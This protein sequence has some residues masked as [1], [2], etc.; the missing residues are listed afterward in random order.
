MSQAGILSDS[1]SPAADV[2][3]LQGNSGGKV[4]PDA[5]FN[6][7]TVGTGSITID[8]NPGTNTLT[9]QLTGLTNHNVLVGAG[10]AT[11]TK[12]A[13]SAGTGIALVSNGAAADPSFTTVSVAGGGLG[14]TTVPSNGQIPIGN[15]TNYTVANL[16]AGTGI[17]IAN[18]AGSITISVSGTGL[19][20]T[21]V[22]GT[23]QT[24]A[25]SNGY[26]SDNAGTVTFTLP[27]TASLGDT[28]Q[29]VGKLGAWTIAQNANQ[30]IRVS[31]T[32]STVG[33]GGSVSS[34]NVGDCI[35]CTCITSGASTVWRAT[36]VVGN[37]TVV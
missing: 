23:T 35:E 24:I 34:T 7:F 11:I 13:P 31:G 14:V 3:T 32:N 33:V 22:T 26:V 28:W 21:D 25:V 6:I 15:G 30:Q 36:S 19:S 18:A 4:S 29:I 2:E 37:L 16:T 8:G 17:S 5:T 10:T 9:T 27:A 12:V 1:T 20:W